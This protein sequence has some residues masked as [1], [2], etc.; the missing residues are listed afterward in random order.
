MKTSI[1]TTLA[2]LALTAV[3][4]GPV[5]ANISG[6]P[7]QGAVGSAVTEGNVNVNVDDGVATLFGWTGTQI[8]ADAAKRAALSFDNVDSVVDLIT[9][10]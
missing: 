5:S 2:V 6:Q 9:V 1:K 3:V 7:L 10:N 4:A 8:E